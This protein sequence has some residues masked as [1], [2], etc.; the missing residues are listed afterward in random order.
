MIRQPSTASLVDA[1]LAIVQPHVK[2]LP[3]VLPRPRCDRHPRRLAV[4]TTPD[5]SF[6]RECRPVRP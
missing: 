4:V 1:I 3:P 6:C 5:G 2:N